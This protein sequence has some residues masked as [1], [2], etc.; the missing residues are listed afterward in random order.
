M[1]QEMKFKNSKISNTIFLTLFTLIF[2]SGVSNA[3]DKYA[4]D[5][6]HS[7]VGF[8]VKHMV[9]STIRGS[10][11]DFKV[12]LEYDSKNIV[13]SQVKATIYTKSIDTGIEKRDGHLMSPDF[14][15]VET[16][17]EMTF[18]SKSVMKKGKDYILKGTLTIKGISKEVEIPFT[19][20]GPIKDPY[21]S[22]RI[23]VEGHL[24][25]NRQDFN[26]KWNMTLD[27]GGLVVSDNVEIDLTLEATKI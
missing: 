19:L 6:M 24:T 5:M 25:I 18:T 11:T 17:P 2:T 10:F 3:G 4:V 21:G 12:D 1:E 14:F 13:N 23:G 20:M 27:G 26:V 15:D 22:A 9:I 8:A 16:F 7:S